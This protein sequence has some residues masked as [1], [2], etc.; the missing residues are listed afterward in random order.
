MK[1][2]LRRLLAA[3]SLLV[4]GGVAGEALAE[5]PADY[6]YDTADPS[7][8]YSQPD[9]NAGYNTNWEPKRAW[10]LSY[11]EKDHVVTLKGGAKSDEDVAY[12]IA[13][14]TLFGTDIARASPRRRRRRPVCRS[15]AAP[16]ARRPARR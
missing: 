7:A 9:P 10:I 6:G 4:S 15:A 3:A 16:D 8:G 11:V 1:T 5:G 12:A 13:C 14:V 2:T